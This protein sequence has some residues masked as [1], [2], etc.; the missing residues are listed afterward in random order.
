MDEGRRPI[1]TRLSRVVREK[2][3]VGAWF[4][5]LSKIGYRRLVLLER[6]LDEP[7]PEIVP[8]V[9]AE[10]RRLGPDDRADF[11]AL[12]QGDASVFRERLERGHHCWG[13]WCSGS[14]RHIAWIAF[15]ET[16]VEYLNCRLR[17]NDDVAYI[18]RAFTHPEYRRLDLGPARQAA[19]LTALRGQGY[20]AAIAAVLPDNP[21]ASASWHKVGYRR[22]G[23]VRALGTG[24][25][26]RIYT[27]L[28]RAAGV[29]ARWRFERSRAT[30][31]P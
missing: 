9:E 12:G 11:E 18:Y 3:P 23:V 10:I 19:C 13:A 4:G 17:L 14:L 30:T 27:R 26:P 25:Q 31:S 29:E 20:T 8:R 6:R 1:W 5:L 28:D 16:R 7:L 2:G 15:G 21:W 22:I 24:R